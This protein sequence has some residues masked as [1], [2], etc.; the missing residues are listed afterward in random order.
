MFKGLSI[1]Q[2]D[3]NNY[4]VPEKLG[5]QITQHVQQ[6]HPNSHGQAFSGDWRGNGEG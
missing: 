3:L 6:G 5:I 4:E 1:I 2:I